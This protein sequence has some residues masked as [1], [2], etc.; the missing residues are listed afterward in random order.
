MESRPEL[1]GSVGP[2]RGDHAAVTRTLNA[3]DKEEMRI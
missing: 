2:E 3:M 1:E